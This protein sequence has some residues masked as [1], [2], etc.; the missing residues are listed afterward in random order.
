MGATRAI[1]VI[2]TDFTVATRWRRGEEYQ[3]LLSADTAEASVED[4]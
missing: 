1:P 3:S 2:G 4:P